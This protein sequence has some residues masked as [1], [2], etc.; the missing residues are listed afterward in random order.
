MHVVLLNQYYPPDVAPTGVMLEAVAEAIVARGHHVTVICAE[1]GYGS[2]EK[3]K[4]YREKG[5]GALGGN[6]RV[7]RI[8]ATRCGRGS[9]AAKLLDYA[10]YYLGVIGKLSTLEP[11][12]DR[13]VALTTPPYLSVLARVMSKLRRGDHAH[14]VMDL[15]PDVMVSHGMLRPDALA[16]RALRVLTRW[17]FGGRRNRLVLT[18]GPDMARRAET[19][20]SKATPQQWVPL[21]GMASQPLGDG[22]GSSSCKPEISSASRP[23]VLMYSGNMGLGHRFGEFLEASVTHGSDLRW[24]FYGEGKRRPEIEAFIQQHPE[25]PV[26]LGGYVPRAELADHLASADVH[27]ASLDPAWDGTMVPSKLQGIFSMGK[28][29]LF[30]GSETSSIGRWILTS[31]G[32]WVIAPGDT[33]AM[34]VALDEALVPAIRQEKGERALAYAQEHFDRERNAALIAQSFTKEVKLAINK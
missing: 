9:F 19:Y 7:V 8:R 29:V 17:S 27:L 28:P 2:E 30:V 3:T 20:L 1:G 33:T 34:S 5:E 14:W 15:Y 13:I 18:L 23:L 32:G 4:K 21:W 10:S 16:T 26:E 24:C 6:L 25:A 22:E 31:G 11:A 12:P